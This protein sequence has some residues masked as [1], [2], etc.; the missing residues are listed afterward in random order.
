MYSQMSKVSEFCQ[1]DFCEF[2]LWRDSNSNRPAVWCRCKLAKFRLIWFVG[3]TEYTIYI[4]YQSVCPFVG[5]RPPPLPSPHA[6]VSP[7][8][9]PKKGE[10]NSL[11]GE[12]VGGTQFGRLDR[13]PGTLYTT[14]PLRFVI[15]VS[16]ESKD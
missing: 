8:L 9:D 6:S 12:G 4:K 7:P 3:N 2:R 13:K 16:G 15:Y 11:A 14:I 10:Q 1:N 5:I